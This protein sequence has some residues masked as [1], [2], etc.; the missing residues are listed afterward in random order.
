MNKK[1]LTAG[2]LWSL[3]SIC[4]GLAGYNL[5]SANEARAA[6]ALTRQRYAAVLSAKRDTLAHPTMQGSNAAE[7]DSI[8]EPQHPSQLSEAA[9]LA[10]DP[11]LYALE[12]T[13]FR[14]GLGWKFGPFYRARNLA[15]EKVA[16]LEALAVRHHETENDIKAVASAQNEAAD[17]PAV[18]ALEKQENDQYDASLRALLGETD[19][20]S[21]KYYDRAAPVYGIVDYLANNLALSSEPLTTPQVDQV[22]KI[23]ADSSSNYQ[24]GGVATR[25]TID[26]PTAMGQAEGVLS[27]A[28]FEVL[29]GA[30][31]KVQVEQ[32]S[33]Q[34]LKQD[35]GSSQKN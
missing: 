11:K 23:L 27:P 4:L 30:A 9:L 15:S 5:H 20:Q 2:V 3:V 26:W 18:T 22:L 1:A 29:Q 34:F 35:T 24:R 19:F 8:P 10:T 32:L 33:A 31:A 16:A 17:G 21:F 6:L 12:A 28:Q 14:A 25:M 13:A 7:E